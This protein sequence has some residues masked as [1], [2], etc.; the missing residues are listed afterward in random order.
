MLA[1]LMLDDHPADTDPGWKVVLSHRVPSLAAASVAPTFAELLDSTPEYNQN[2]T[3][4]SPLDFDWALHPGGSTVITG[5]EKEMGL[6]AE[7]LRASYLVYMA[8]GN[9]SS[10]TVF[11]VL[12]KL[13]KIGEGKED[14]MGCAFGPGIAIE[15]I[16]LKRRNGGDLQNGDGLQ[17][18]DS[19][20]HEDQPTAN[21]SHEQT[22]GANGH[23]TNGTNGF[24]DET[25]GLPVESV[26]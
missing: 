22:N 25:N 16:G 14:V 10:A 9:S 7:H 26:D 24:T 8:H 12:D 15:M 21:G 19:R 2:G 4:L 23:Y 13:R 11:S 3:A 6:T 5:V 20:Q 17:N 1:A 18:G